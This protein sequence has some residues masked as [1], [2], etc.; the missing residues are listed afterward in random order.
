MNFMTLKAEFDQDVKISRASARSAL[1]GFVNGLTKADFERKDSKTLVTTRRF[2]LTG[3]NKLLTEDQ[4]FDVDMVHKAILR[5]GFYR[6]SPLDGLAKDGFR[7][8]AKQGCGNI[9]FEVEYA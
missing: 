6:L 9:Y 3:I 2:T 7:I 1:L 5:D 4:K 8:S